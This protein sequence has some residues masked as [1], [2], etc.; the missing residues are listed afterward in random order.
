MRENLYLLSVKKSPLSNKKFRALFQRGTKTFSV[1]FGARGYSDYTLHKDK[2][3]KKR[4]ISR[5]MRDLRTK[6]PSRAGYLS[7]FILWN[8]PTF[9]AS[10]KD[11][12]R[13]LSIYNR[14]GKF[15]TD[16]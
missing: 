7:M 2:E 14:T 11:Y 10:L 12:K 16:I 13:R 3:R 5:H 15:P 9:Q 6:D 8:K 1:D 4:Y